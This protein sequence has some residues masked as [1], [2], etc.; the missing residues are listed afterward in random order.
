MGLT[1]SLNI[2]LQSM[3]VEQGAIE[4][5]TNNIANVNTPGYARQRPDIAETTP[6]QIGNL[7]FGSGVQLQSVT[8]LRDSVLDL[9]VNQETQLQGSLTALLNVG[10]QI[11]QLFNQAAGSGLQ[12]Q[13]TSFF[14]SLSALA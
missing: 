14:N 13:L 1:A 10:G 12:T 7:T 8:S 9:R 11:Q 3:L 2:S 5:T 4:T 6:I